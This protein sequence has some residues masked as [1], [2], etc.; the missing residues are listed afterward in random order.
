MIQGGGAA[1]CKEA[2]IAVRNYIQ[3]FNK[4][5]NEEVCYLICQVHDA[6]DLE[7]KDEFADE[8]MDQVCKLM[9]QEGNKY[10]TKTNMDVDPTKTKQWQK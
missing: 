10:V 9:V 1:A 5:H 2:L 7:V 6:I 3:E 4:L 8:V